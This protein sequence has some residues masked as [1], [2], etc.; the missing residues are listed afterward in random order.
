MNIDAEKE[1]EKKIRETILNGPTRVVIDESGEATT[2]GCAKDDHGIVPTVIFLRDDG[3]TLGAPEQFREVARKMWDDEYIAMAWYSEI[4]QCWFWA[5]FGAAAPRVVP[6][7][8]MDDFGV[9]A[10][11]DD[12]SN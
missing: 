10:I 8:T 4:H 12:E 7:R 3:W 2:P 1:L 9:A 6:V 5:R 11:I